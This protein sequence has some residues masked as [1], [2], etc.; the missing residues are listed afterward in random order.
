MKT[1]LFVVAF[2]SGC[3]CDEVRPALRFPVRESRPCPSVTGDPKLLTVG[4]ELFEGPLHCS[5][6]PGLAFIR[7]RGSG[8]RRLVLK[9]TG[10]GDCDTLAPDDAAAAACTE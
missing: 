8:P 1:Y 2:V 6:S 3:A 10:E 5:K 4:S 9:N 7:V